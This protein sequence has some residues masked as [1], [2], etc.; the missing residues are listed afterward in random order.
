[1]KTALSPKDFFLHVGV[2][3]TLYWATA[4]LITLVFQIINIALPDATQSFYYD[5]YSGP[6]RFA[7]ASLI[8][9]FPAFLFLS[10]L[11]RKTYEK[12][13]EKR[14]SG[15]RKFLI[16]LT[17]FLAGGI[18]LGDLV[19]IL[20]SFLGGELSL[21][22]FLK[23]VTL[24]AVL[25]LIFGYYIYELRKKTPK[26]TSVTRTYEWIAVV[27]VIAAVVVG[28]YYLGSPF[29]QRDMTLD[30]ERVNDL[31]SLQWQI[32][33][34]YQAKEVLPGS[35]SEIEDSL[36]GFRIPTDPETGESY[37]YSVTGDLSFELCALFAHQS[38]PRVEYSLA[39][40]ADRYG[41]DSNWE[42][43][44]GRDCFERTI[45]P[46]LYPPLKQ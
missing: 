36:S 15:F 25:G 29:T 37:E 41:L 34:Y 5:P 28:F 3:A 6:I 4:S 11:V 42:H 26:K 1:M 22:F 12:D 20:N 33:N 21:R 40:P 10:K 46:D 43:E 8:I 2:I 19:A 31:Q 27:A 13:A 38:D 23:A 30:R 14:D 7:I 16:Y 45:D 44:A 18:I 17:L 35:L 39:Y 9:V 32:V 24:G